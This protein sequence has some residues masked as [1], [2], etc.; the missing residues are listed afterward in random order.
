VI[1][2]TQSD[3]SDDENV[4]EYFYKAMKSANPMDRLFAITKVNKILKTY[5]NVDFDDRLDVE[6]IRGIYRKKT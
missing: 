3:E 2:S 6:L 1:E 4:D 5:A